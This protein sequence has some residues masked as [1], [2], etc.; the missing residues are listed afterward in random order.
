MPR[1]TYQAGDSSRTEY[2]SRLE[3]DE[4]TEHWVFPIGTLDDGEVVRHRVPR[5]SV[6]FI[7]E[8][9]SEDIELSPN[10][11]IDTTQS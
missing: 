5:E 7:G 3:F 2:P 11:R 8:T 6:H 9:D 4:D 1:I 10:T